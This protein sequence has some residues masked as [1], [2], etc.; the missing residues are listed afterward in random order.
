MLPLEDEPELEP[1]D[2]ELV[3][4]LEGDILPP[5]PELEGDMLPLLPDEVPELPAVIPCWAALALD[6]ALLRNCEGSPIL[7]E[8]E[9]I[10]FG[11][12]LPLELPPLPLP[13]VDEL[14]PPLLVEEELPLP[15]PLPDEDIPLPDP[16]VPEPL[17]DDEA[18]ELPD[19]IPCCAALALDPAL[20][21]NKLGSPILLLGEL[22]A[23]GSKLLP[24]LPLLNCKEP[25]GDPALVPD[26]LLEEP[27]LLVD[28]L[29]LELDDDGLLPLDVLPELV[30]L[31]IE[32][33]LDVP[34]KLLSTENG[35]ELPPEDVP[36][37]ELPLDVPEE[38]LPIENGIELPPEDV[39][40]LEVPLEEPE[41]D[42]EPAPDG[43]A[44]PGVGLWVTAEF[45]A[46]GLKLA[47]TR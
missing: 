15:D 2:V 24:P 46:S 38:L 26:P 36:V 9:L 25:D 6:P 13:L 7:L 32:V 31:P 12:K 17:P 43:A 45:T 28:P 19:V 20:L 1:P 16:E 35:I 27:P 37:L 40:P 34:E 14:L 41:E 42:I 5:L 3:P 33:P 18:P 47:A 39:L 29:P 44:P 21:R 30:P 23:F 10:E 22:I 11:S 8:S 4:E